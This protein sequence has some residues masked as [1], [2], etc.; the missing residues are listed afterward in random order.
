MTGAGSI[1]ASRNRSQASRA[2]PP[3]ELGIDERLVAR[4]LSGMCN[5]HAASDAF[6]KTESVQGDLPT[7]PLDHDPDPKGRVSA[8][9]TPVF[10][11]TNAKRLRGD[12]AQIT[13]GAE[14][15]SKKS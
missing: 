4:F 9:Y 12:H 11:A 15:D 13:D 6:A 8:K 14:G 5:S 1:P 10:L 7:I 2:I 3:A